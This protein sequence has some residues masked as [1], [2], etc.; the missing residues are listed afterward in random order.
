[1]TIKELVSGLTNLC[2]ENNLSY[3]DSEPVCV[4]PGV[5]MF[6]AIEMNETCTNGGSCRSRQHYAVLKGSTFALT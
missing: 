4:S 3:G 1:M 6:D 2:K 5:W